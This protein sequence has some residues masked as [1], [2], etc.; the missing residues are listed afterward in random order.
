MN[1]VA[2]CGRIKVGKS[3]FCSLFWCRACAGCIFL[4]VGMKVFHLKREIFFE[5]IGH[6]TAFYFI[7][8]SEIFPHTLGFYV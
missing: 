4:V 8:S 1:I 7:F 2:F 3:Q 5:K 6:N